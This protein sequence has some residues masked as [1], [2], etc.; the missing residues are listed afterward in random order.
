MAGQLRGN[1]GRGKQGQRA[2]RPGQGEG[3]LYGFVLMPS[4]CCSIA[5]QSLYSYLHF[6]IYFSIA[7][8]MPNCCT[9][10]LFLLMEVSISSCLS[11]SITD[12]GIHILVKSRMQL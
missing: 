10:I 5:A 2:G 1:P 3:T 8:Q 12:N 11:I 7:V 6:A 4:N 9:I